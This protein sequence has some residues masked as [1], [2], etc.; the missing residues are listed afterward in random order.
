MQRLEASDERRVGRFVAE[1]AAVELGSQPFPAPFL[2]A[3][4]RLVP[5]DDVVFSE[6]DR[7]REIE[8]GQI[9]E[10]VYDG[11]EAPVSYWEIRH[12]HPTCCHQEVTGDF[13]AH[14]LSEF[15][16]RRELRGS[17]IYADWFHPQGV[18]HELSVGIDAPLWHT[19]VFIFSRASGRDFTERDC[20]VLDAVRHLIAER[21]ALWLSQRRLGQV[22]GLVDSGGSSVVLLDGPDHVAFATEPA[23]ALLERYFGSAPGALPP[24]IVTW[25]G[26]RPGEPL[27]VSADDGSLVVRAVGERAPARGTSRGSGADAP[28]ARGRGARRGGADQRADRRAALDLAGHGAPAPRERVREAGR[29]HADGGCQSAVPRSLGLEAGWDSGQP[30]LAS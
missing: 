20:V 8:L 25:L 17:R 1:T 28:R 26:A 16:S 23:S 3:L 5:S 18:E 14:R 19:K 27:E 30:E 24:A 4:R 22:L 7:V 6:L 9:T 2:S 12:E 10:P 29:Q 15:I 11:P 13:R 21:Y